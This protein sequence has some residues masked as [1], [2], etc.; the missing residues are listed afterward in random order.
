[1]VGLGGGRHVTSYSPVG[2]RQ[3]G[4]LQHLHK[5][6]G[7][8]Q[9]PVGRRQRRLLGFVQNWIFFKMDFSKMGFFKN[10]F[11]KFGIFQIELLP[12]WSI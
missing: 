3:R 11:F 12:N 10:A 2:R 4:L 6:G 8:R 1:M 5:N 7:C 9:R